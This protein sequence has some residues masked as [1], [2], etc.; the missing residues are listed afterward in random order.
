MREYD[1][2]EATPP[3]TFIK[4]VVGERFTIRMPGVRGRIIEPWLGQHPVVD[5]M[6]RS[7]GAG[8]VEF[9][10]IALRSGSELVEFPLIE[11]DWDAASD[12][13]PAK[14]E[15]YACTLVVVLERADKTGNVQR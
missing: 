1:I 3:G 2:T 4:A 12:P 13:D 14:A 7:E 11:E 6:C 10:M 8:F 15:P 5:H 9:E